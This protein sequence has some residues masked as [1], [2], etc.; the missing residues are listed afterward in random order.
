MQ[1]CGRRK[2]RRRPASSGQ[3]APPARAAAPSPRPAPPARARGRRRGRAQQQLDQGGAQPVGLARPRGLL[4]GEAVGRLGRELVDVGEDA[5]GQQDERVG[6]QAGRHAGAGEPAPGDDRPDAVGG[7]QRLQRASLARLAAPEGDV[8]PAARGGPAAGALLR[9]ELLQ[10]LLHADPHRLPEGALQRPGVRGHL[11]AD[12]VDD[13]VGQPGSCGAKA[14]SASGGSASHGRA[15]LSLT[16]K[17]AA[18]IGSK[19]GESTDLRLAHDAMTASRAPDHDRRRRPPLPRVPRR[20]RAALGRRRHGRR[21]RDLRRD[22]RLV[23]L[24]RDGRLPPPAHPP[25]VRRA[26][27]AVRARVR[28]PRLDVG[29]GRRHPLGRRPPQAPRLHRRGGRPAQPPHPRGHR[30]AR[31][32]ARHVALAH[33]LAVRPR[34]SARRRAASRPTCATT[35][36]SASSTA[37][38]SLWVRSAC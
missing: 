18:R 17:S 10:R 33:G 13:L 1:P 6:V 29:A 27:R 8:D 3:R 24:R 4:L 14:A 26:R 32:A 37:T 23:G 25:L 9:A 36:R 28:D 5:L 15:F 19:A 12:R 7:Q 34:P 11:G 16:P 21:P 22:V 31:R 38:S 35:R 2:T 30:L 20:R